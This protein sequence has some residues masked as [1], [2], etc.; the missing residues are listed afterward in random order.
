MLGW[1]WAYINNQDILQVINCINLTT[2]FKKCLPF[3]NAAFIMLGHENNVG[4]RFS[5]EDWHRLVTQ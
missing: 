1:N 2:Y 5:I 3:K 4:K